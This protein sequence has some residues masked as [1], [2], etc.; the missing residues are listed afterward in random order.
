[1]S[2]FEGLDRMMA[3]L[4]QRIG[5]KEVVAVFHTDCAARGR[6]MF[7][8]ILKEEIINKMQYP[9]VGEAQKPWLGMYGFGEFTLLNGKNY[10]HNYT[11]SLYALVR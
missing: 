3:Q 6:A 4:Q 8:K 2:V 7:N 11:T 10:F 5:D 9:L 1:M